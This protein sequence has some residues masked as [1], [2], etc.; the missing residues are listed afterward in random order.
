MNC[1]K[2]HSS[3]FYDGIFGPNC[4]NHNC[5][6]FQGCKVT[7]LAEIKK[8]EYPEMYP[9]MNNI[10]FIGYWNVLN[11]GFG[12]P[13]YPYV[14][15]TDEYICVYNE[16][17]YFDLESFASSF[18]GPIFTKLDEIAIDRKLNNIDTQQ[19]KKIVYDTA[20]KMKLL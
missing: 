10:H 2:C 15:Y 18:K 12:S 3:D 5:I 20:K 13:N 4:T 19:A 16:Y 8:E 7:N 6:Y 14:G 17:D 9:S 1:P 11:N